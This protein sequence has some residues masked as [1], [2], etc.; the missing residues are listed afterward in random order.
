MKN[1][2]K[3]HEK[4]KANQASTNAQIVSFSRRQFHFSRPCPWENIGVASLGPGFRG[5]KAGGS[6]RDVSGARGSKA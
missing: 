3:S 2:V 5:G 4:A 1:E 6:P